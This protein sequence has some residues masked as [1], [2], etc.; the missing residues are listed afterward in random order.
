VNRLR[1]LHGAIVLLTFGSPF[2]G[3]GASEPKIKLDGPRLDFGTVVF[4][5]RISHAFTVRNDG[6]AP[7]LL[8][9]VSSPCE[10]FHADFDKTIGPRQSG[11]I[12]VD[13]DTADLKGPVF[14]TV[15]VRTNDP[16]Q[17][18]APIQIK[19]FVN[20]PVMILPQDH[21]NLTAIQGEDKEQVLTLEVNRKSPLKV[22][23]V[24][25]TTAVFAPTLEIVTRGKRYRIT[26]RADAKQPVGVHNGTI[27]IRTDDPKQPVI[28]IE[29]T[30]L[31]VSSVV[32]EPSTLYL[33][34]LDQDEA[35]KGTG[36][37]NWK[38]ALKNVRNRPFA[39]VAVTSDLPFIRAWSQARQEATSQEI[40]VA[41]DQNDFL[42]PGKTISK[43][44]VKTSLPDAQ[45]V[46][47]PVWV[48]VRQ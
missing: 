22:K 26:V 12:K 27:R 1:A 25:S 43:V 24:E 14:L 15:M 3:R 45:D 36:K 37:K 32:V 6:D 33:P 20:G 38:V 46:Q 41:V 8:Q 39:I 34:P 10:C 44:H 28:A 11:R 23:T 40:L 42:K 17:R 4:G 31:V 2:A 47:I 7:L 5:Q 35:H 16:Q 9:E 30:L 29:C 13:I 19:G 21:L 18:V 48:E